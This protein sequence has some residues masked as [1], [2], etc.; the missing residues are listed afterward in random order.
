MNSDKSSLRKQG[1]HARDAL[2]RDA[3]ARA[4]KAIAAQLL[5]IIPPGEIVAAYSAI[6]GEVD[7]TEAMQAFAQRGNVMCL[8]VVVEDAPL[9]F[10]H[11]KPGQPLQQG[12]YGIDVPLPGQ[13]LL[14]PDVVLAP[15]VAFD[16]VGHRLGYGA[17]YYDRTIQWLRKNEK[18]VQIIGV[19]YAMQ[20]TDAIPADAHDQRLDAVV[21]EK[22]IMK[23]A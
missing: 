11:W 15:L 7:L 21:T 14:V 20:Q 13:P 16:K 3:R 6:R 10:R 4:E 8:P 23:T 19:A 2:P 1:I 12:A 18:S 9:L 17:G 22:G 5:K